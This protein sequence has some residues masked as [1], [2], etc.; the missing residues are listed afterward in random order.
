MLKFICRGFRF[1]RRALTRLTRQRWRQRRNGNHCKFE[2]GMVYIA[3][4]EAPKCVHTAKHY[5]RIIAQCFL[6]STLNGRRTLD[7][8]E[9]GL[10]LKLERGHDFAIAIHEI[11]RR[12]V[13]RSF[14]GRARISPV[15]GHRA[16]EHGTQ[17]QRVRFSRRSP[18]PARPPYCAGAVPLTRHGSGGSPVSGGGCPDMGLPPG[19]GR[20]ETNEVSGAGRPAGSRKPGPSGDRAPGR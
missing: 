10:A 5:L 17:F 12:G 7:L 20:G 2:P 13:G 9:F 16:L 6:L 19:S 11:R 3:S 14:H 1:S 8:T 15:S 18:S 4:S